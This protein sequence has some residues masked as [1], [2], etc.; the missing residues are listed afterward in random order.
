MKQI[1]LHKKESNSIVLTSVYAMVDDE[2]YERLSK[3][4]WYIMRLYH[5]NTDILYARRYE[6]S[7]K[8]GNHKAILMHREVLGATSRLEKIDHKDGNG[9]NNQKNNI[10]KCTHSENMSNRKVSHKKSNK[11]LGV[12]FKKNEDSYQA[13][14]KKDG[15]VYSTG[16]FKTT[17]QAAQA[18]NDLVLKYNP[19]YGRLNIII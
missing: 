5:C 9:L 7:P 19:I 18:Y 3:N 16:Y 6:G 10:R 1:F 12:F 11:Y 4:K 14:L 2:D 8:N 15:K 13:A 17:E